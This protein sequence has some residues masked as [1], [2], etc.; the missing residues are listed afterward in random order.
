MTRV[1]LFATLIAVLGIPRAPA[2][3]LVPRTGP[4]DSLVARSRAQ[5]A[6]DLMDL[7]IRSALEDAWVHFE[8][9]GA[10]WWLDVGKGEGIDRVTIDVPWPRLSEYLKNGEKRAS[11]YHV[12]PVAGELVEAARRYRPMT[13]GTESE[14]RLAIL[15]R[16]PGLWA[17]PPGRTDF[18]GAA[19]LARQ[20][21]EH[22]IALSVHVAVPEGIFTYGGNSS[23]D[24]Q[25][26]W[27]Y[28]DPEGYVRPGDRERLVAALAALGL[29]LEFDERRRLAD[30]RDFR[31]ALA[32]AIRGEAPVW[33]RAP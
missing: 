19:L 29:S 28:L 7:A 20:A 25:R 31:D 16:T 4:G 13:H 2:Q 12:H 5:G 26:A 8:I 9:E 14:Y 23:G 30:S 21:A 33:R 24:L 1:L 15:E 18:M 6:G 11:I 22:G 17:R 27:T 32:E 10:G 3:S